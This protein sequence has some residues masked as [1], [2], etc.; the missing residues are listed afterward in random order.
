MAT[1]KS[2]IQENID[3]I[4]MVPR[5]AIAFES[6]DTVKS[7]VINT[8]ALTNRIVLTMPT[9]SGAVVTATL[10]IEN[11]DGEEIYSKGGLVESGTHVMI[12]EVEL[13]GDN[14]FKVTLSTDPLSSGICYLS[15]YLKGV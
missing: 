15:V 10:S 2:S 13:V 4:E 5:T 7:Q 6:G 11:S 8:N 3:T 9:F 1:I 12:T 14:T